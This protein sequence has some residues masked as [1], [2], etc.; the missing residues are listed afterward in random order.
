[1]ASDSVLECEE[2]L[3]HCPQVLTLKFPDNKKLV[4]T[5]LNNLWILDSFNIT[6]ESA[7]RTEMYRSEFMR[8]EEVKR[9]GN[10]QSLSHEDN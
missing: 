1:M 8:Q 7:K 5:V 10:I 2:L 9:L 4:S 3:S 6:S